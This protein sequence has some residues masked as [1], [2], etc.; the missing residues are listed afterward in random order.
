MF[1]LSRIGRSWVV[2]AAL[3]FS[4]LAAPAL[5]ASQVITLTSL[6]GVRFDIPELRQVQMQPGVFI[7]EQLPDASQKKPFFVL[8]GSIEEAPAGR[9]DDAAWEAVRANI[10][11]TASSEGR[12]MKLELGGEAEGPIGF[13]TR[14]MRGSYDS[15][16]GQEMALE[17]VVLVKD[18]RLITISLLSPTMTQELRSQLYAVGRSVRLG[19]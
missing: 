5:A 17:L 7:L 3:A 11:R 16:R 6:G 15:E 4:G 1:A 18:E 13:Q 14:V 19:R 10:Q 9:L 8:V 2:S 12:L